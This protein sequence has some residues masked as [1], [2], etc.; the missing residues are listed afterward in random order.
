M[1]T[2]SGA[3]NVKPA[4]CSGFR[5]NSGHVEG[6]QTEHQYGKLENEFFRV[7]TSKLLSNYLQ[8]LTRLETRMDGR[9]AIFL[10]LESLNGKPECLV[11]EPELP[12]Q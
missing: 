2:G 10:F 4:T 7:H 11:Q 8:I 5:R 9:Y 12:R 6:S 1:A 3:A